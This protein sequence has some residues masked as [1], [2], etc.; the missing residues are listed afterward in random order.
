MRINAKDPILISCIADFLKIYLPS[1]RN[2][3]QNT[4]DSYRNT[5]NLYLL[6]LQTT[7]DITL[8]TIHSED[9]SQKNIILFM[10][11][12]KDERGNAAPTI[13]HRLSDIRGFC[14]YLAK[15]KAITLISYEEIRE[16]KDVIDERV[17]DFTWLSVNDIKSV[18]EQ[19]SASR[20]SIRDRFL[21]S[22]LYE[23]GA[24]IDE[25]LS[26]TLKDIRPVSGGEADVHFFGKGR[27]HRITPLSGEIWNQYQNYCEKY[28]PQ[29]EHDELLFYTFRNNKRNKMSQD[30]ISRILN[31]CEGHL[32]E[33][34]PDLLHL[35]AHLFRRSRAMHLYEAGVPLPTIS[36]WLGHSN[37]ETTRFYA[38]I[39]TKM[40]RDA[41]HK[42]SESD[43]SVFK[44]DVA[45]KY[46]GN[47]DML[48]RL[49]GLK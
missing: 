23:S 18:L 17:S 11:W 13:N 29:K 34:Q 8:M 1:V 10:S 44:D 31:T 21:F 7:F 42:L 26:L 41:L 33:K 15:K 49:C 30:N 46:A 6:F 40:K 45:F 5:I 28:H 35:H 3:H 43:K 9:F 47:E 4:I 36:E 16:I 27:K 48:K 37:I 19:I 24:R 12:L 22:L 20:D 14:K 2:R 39:T 32:R 25:V 38:Q